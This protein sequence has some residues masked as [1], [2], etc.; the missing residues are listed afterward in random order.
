[1]LKKIFGLLVIL[2]FIG[3]C[4]YAYAFYL[5]NKTASPP[6]PADIEK[7]YEKS[8]DWLVNNYPTLKHN[9]NPALW[10][11][12]KEATDISDN[13][14]LAGVFAQYKA[15][16]LDTVPPN[17]WTPYFR[18]YY[19]PAVPDITFM[20]DF[21]P[22]QKFFVYALSCDKALAQE[23]VI[24]QQLEADFCGM[25]YLHPR[26]VTHQLMSVRL[27]QARYCGDDTQLAALSGALQAIII[28]E[29]TFDFRVTDSYLQRVLML[30]ETG[31]ISAIKPVWLQ[32]ILAAQNADGGWD[33]LHP[34][35]TL[36]DA[37]VFGWSSTLPR[38]RKIESDFHA[39]AQG[40]WLLALLLQHQPASDQAV[41]IKN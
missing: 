3:V 16:Y 29:L 14:K 2:M 39:T 33:D 31:N 12:L 13:K 25:H 30:A 40:M 23:N 17:L 4:Y 19:K 7:A 22:Y 35:L 32:R 1:M 20:Q 5:N 27:M 21:Q 8:V 26:C 28:D 15:D 38:F 10:W 36:D 9:H 41:I 24:K 6:H 18:K 11:M 34:V 37:R